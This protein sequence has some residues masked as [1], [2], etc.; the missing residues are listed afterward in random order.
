MNP[1]L[2]L[3]SLAAI[4]VTA[5][6]AARLFPVKNP[7]DD[8]RVTRNLMRYEPDAVVGD[9]YITTDGKAALAKLEAP[10]ESIG[11]TVQLGD[12]VVCRILRAAD[13]KK[14]ETRDDKLV[15]RFDDFTQP[16]VTRPFDADS[17][18]AVRA[19]V[20]KVARTQPAN[21]PDQEKEA[22]HAA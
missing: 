17:L 12:R 18:S 11:M 2:L 21:Q 19:L 3:G 22:S 10:E 1:I 5:F 14:A 13:I 20:N 6:I 16:S 4:V 8:G 7:L 15:I 9:I